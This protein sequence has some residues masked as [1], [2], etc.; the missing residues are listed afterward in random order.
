MQ[1][2]WVDVGAKKNRP[3]RGAPG[4][5][6][7]AG[8]GLDAVP[9]VFVKKFPA[10]G[11]RSLEPVQPRR[12]VRGHQG[13]FDQQG[14]AS[15]HRVEQ[16]AAFCVEFLPAAPDQHGRGQVL[17]QRR[18]ALRLPP[19]ATVQ[20]AAA[21]V[22]RDDAPALAHHQADPQ[23]GGLGVHRRPRAVGRA[24]AIDDSVL[25][26]LGGVAFVRKCR[27]RDVRVYGQR[28]L[29]RE[30][31]VPVD[32]V[33]ALV[34]VVLVGAVE[35]G[36]RPQ[37]AAGEARIHHGP[38]GG[39]GSAL[40]VGAGQRGCRFGRAQGHQFVRQEIFQP[41][42]AGDEEFHDASICRKRPNSSAQNSTCAARRWLSGTSTSVSWRRWAQR[43]TSRAGISSS[44]QP[45]TM[46]VGTI[47]ALR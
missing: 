40:G 47:A 10:R 42:S 6:A 20:R 32:G 17:L 13:T 30:M 34:Q 8:V 45:C 28:A 21:N 29:G 26:A 24:H 4:V 46:R 1:R 3:E 37:H 41:L 15:A 43:T 5:G 39:L 19:A 14:A 36:Q 11:Q 44:S 23:V 2:R 31:L 38:V 16:C 22:D 12:D 9:Q 35:F 18:F 7:L 25:G 33:H 27:T